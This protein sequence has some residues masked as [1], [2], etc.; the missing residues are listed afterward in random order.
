MSSL[1]LPFASSLA[2]KSFCFQMSFIQVFIESFERL[3]SKDLELAEIP[4][5]GIIIM[6]V[7]IL[8]KF[9]VRS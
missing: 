4:L 8:V 5:N 3:V 7:T 9:I 2:D 1:P 6:V